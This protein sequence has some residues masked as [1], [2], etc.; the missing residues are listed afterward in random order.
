[1]NLSNAFVSIAGCLV[2]VL[3]LFASASPRAQELAA[4]TAVDVARFSAAAAGSPLPEGWKPWLITKTKKPTAYSLAAVDGRV[5]LKAVANASATGL[6]RDMRIELKEFPL[7]RWQWKTENLIP[8][9]DNYAKDRE[10][11][12]VRLVIRFEGD[13][14]KLPFKDRLVLRLAKT[15]SGQELPYA[16]LM[17]IWENKAPRGSVIPNPHTGRVQMIVAESG[18]ARVGQWLTEEHNVYEDYKRAF[19]EEPPPVSAVGV[20]T[21][22]DNTD[23]TAT[24]W[25]GDIAFRKAG[26]PKE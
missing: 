2:C 26:K 15:L 6:M 4:P 21:D 14:G 10:D 12:P 16:T 19:G 8:H 18:P 20:L 23:E 24:A 1:M 9:A 13:I 3:A 25:Y 22:T 17:Y 5:A 11:S 7:L